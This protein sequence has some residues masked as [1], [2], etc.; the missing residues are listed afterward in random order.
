MYKLPDNAEKTL[1]DTF[2]RTMIITIAMIL[3]CP[4]IFAVGYFLVENSVVKPDIHESSI[5]ILKTTFFAISIVSALASIFLKRYLLDPNNHEKTANL[6]SVIQK[7]MIFT[8]IVYAIADIPI[9]LGFVYYILSGNIIV[10]EMYIVIS[11]TVFVLCFPR[12]Q[13]W[14]DLLLFLVRNRPSIIET[15]EQQA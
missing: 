3:D 8:I 14:K 4:L 15:I 12:L 1:L 9:L 5:S 10:F 7:L 6:N 11:V 2:K 13:S